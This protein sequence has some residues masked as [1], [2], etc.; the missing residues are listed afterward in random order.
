VELIRCAL[1]HSQHICFITGILP[2]DYTESSRGKGFG[3]GLV[4]LGYAFIPMRLQEWQ[5]LM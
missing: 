4:Y 1:F 3:I 5:V 2:S